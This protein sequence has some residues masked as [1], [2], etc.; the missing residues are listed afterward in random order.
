MS[1]AP[2][3]MP[4]P[5][6]RKPIHDLDLGDGHWLDWTSYQGQRCGGIITHT[7]A[8]SPTNE[9]GL[10]SG[11]FWID[12]NAFYRAQG[13]TRPIWQLTGPD[14]APTMTPSF[15]CHC[16]DHGWVRDGKWVRV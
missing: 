16:G 9:T 7:C 11:S 5:N 15:L 8:I 4:T 14:T 1:D 6:D 10:C 13:T 3:E 2:F 12:G